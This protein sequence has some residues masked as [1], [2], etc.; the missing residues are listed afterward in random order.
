M[1]TLSH[2]LWASL[3]YKGLKIKTKKSFNI[4]LAFFWGIFP[5]VLAFSTSSMWVILEFV[6]GKMEFRELPRPDTDDPYYLHNVGPFKL[7]LFLYGVGHSLVIFLAIFFLMWLILKRP[8]WEMGAWLSHILID[9]PTH[10]LGDYAT[11]IFWP[12]SHW[13][14]DG[15]SWEH[16]W[17]IA[18]N[19]LT[20]I[21][22]FLYLRKRRK[23]AN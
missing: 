11:P 6:S 9:L 4:G 19:Y 20:I 16:R 15:Y 2:G 8:V 5:D 14:F 7:A 10:S 12:L 21:L 18:L 17:F 3:I 13:R 23:I 1:D 22:L